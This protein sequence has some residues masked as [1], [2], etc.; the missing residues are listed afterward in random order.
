VKRLLFNQPLVKG[1]PREVAAYWVTRENDGPLPPEDQ[2]ARDAWLAEHPGHVGAYD[3]TGRAMARLEA[4]AADARILALRDTAL[5]VRAERRAPVWRLAAAFMAA[6]VLAGGSWSVLSPNGQVPSA[7]A[8]LTPFINPD[9]AVYG[10]AVG[11]RS[12]VTLPDGSVAT[13]NTDTVLKLAFT[14]QARGVRLVR[15]QALFEVAHNK[16][17]PFEVYAGDRTITAVGTVFDVRLDGKAVKVALVEG[18]VRVRQRLSL[19]PA[20]TPAPQIVMSAGEVLE[21]RPTEPMVVKTLD[22]GRQTSWRS[23]VVV[24]DETPLRDAIAELNRYSNEQLVIEDASIANLHVTGVFKTG[25]LTRFART[26]EEIL[27]VAVEVG[28]RGSTV[29]TRRPE[30]ISGRG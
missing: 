29:L 1:D 25:D 3:A 8:R 7:V 20:A 12:T 24:F 27:P 2:S 9:A 28:P 26:V 17:R 13:L 23:G 15:G 19:A 16:G 6:A 10:T 22:M 11:E 18:V 30:S 4:S 21:A 5:A 14:D